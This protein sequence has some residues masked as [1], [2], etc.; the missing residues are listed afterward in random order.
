ME[1][2]YTSAD[3]IDFNIDEIP[4]MPVPKR[5]LMVEPTYYDV[6]YVINPHMTDRIGTVNAARARAEWNHLR[7]GFRKLGLEVVTIEGRPR[8]PDMVFCANQ[9]LP[10][11]DEN[12]NKKVIMGI[13]HAEQR[14]GEVPFI[15]QWF[16]E[17][18]Y[19]VF[20]LDQKKVP[21]F[22][23]MGDAIWHFERELLWGGFGF[24]SSVQAY[25]E[26]SGM[27]DVPVILLELKDERYYHLDTCFCPLNTNSVLIYPLAF[28]NQG[29]ELIYSLYENVIEADTYEA[30]KL[31]AVNAAAPDGKNVLIQ[32]GSM[33]VNNKLTDLGFNV[34]EFDTYEFLKSGGS[35]FCM[36]LLLW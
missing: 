29:L 34:H 13:M 17:N 7:D 36:K 12:G 27:L 28:S 5:V 4:R 20:H 15:E 16:R 10:Y 31:F 22:E 32:R 1:K 14:K 35:V 24:R 2:I 23:G 8:L 21:D 33:N 19:E 9:S 6:Q 3:Q 11:C 18:G 26:I 30:E 25:E